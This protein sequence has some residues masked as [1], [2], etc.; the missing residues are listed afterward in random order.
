LGKYLE[1]AGKMT[2]QFKYICKKCG[3]ERDGVLEYDDY[4]TVCPECGEWY[5]TIQV[6]ENKG[7]N[8]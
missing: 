1:R 3:Y 7:G 8:K 5:K 2:D 4:S 6:D